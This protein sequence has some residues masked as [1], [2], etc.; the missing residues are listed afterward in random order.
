[1]NSKFSFIL[2]AGGFGTSLREHYP[3]IH[4]SLI[5]INNIPSICIL[6]ETL[7]QLDEFIQIIYIICFKRYASSFHKQISK[8]FY[9]NYKIKLISVEDN[10]GSALSCK[11]FMD[12]HTI[13]SDNI[14]ILNS[15]IP[16]L[17][18]YTLS[19]FINNSIDKTINICVSNLKKNIEDYEKFVNQDDTLFIESHLNLDIEN[20]DFIY[21]NLFFIKKTILK[22]SLLNLQK[23][24]YSHEYEIFDIFNYLNL[25]INNFYIVNSY[26]AN[27]EF[28]LLKSNDDK[29]MIEDFFIE[30]KN[31]IFI[32]QCYEFWKKFD[33]LENRIHFLENKFDI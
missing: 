14:C 26:V 22:N 31:A 17:S 10:E 30:K 15:N 9:N 6:L 24:S 27:K 5:P 1:M 8:R 11:F 13:E 4:K 21:C 19:E 3:N 32:T 33:S 18:F 29:N 7:L 20:N 16:L 2:L 23:N 25:N 12:H 28:I